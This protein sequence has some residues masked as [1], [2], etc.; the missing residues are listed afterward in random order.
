[1]KNIC[2]LHFPRIADFH[3]YSID[4]LDPRPYFKN[5]QSPW[6]KVILGRHLLQA[7]YID[8]M[9]REKDP[10]YM[11]FLDDFIAKFENAHVIIA[12]SNNPVHPEV[13]YRD[14]KGPVKIAGFTDDPQATYIRGIPYQWA[15]DGAF[16]ISPSYNDEFLFKDALAR[17]GCDYS[18]W[19]PLVWPRMSGGTESGLW[20]LQEAREAAD[21]KGDGFFSQRDIDLIYVGNYYDP[22]VDR[23]VELNKRFGSRL[24][25][26][27][28]WR[29]SGYRG[30]M[31]WALGKAPLWRRVSPLSD[32]E[33]AQLYFRARIGINM[34]LSGTPME[35]GNMR[36]YEVAAHGAM[37]LCDKGG[38]NAHEFIFEPDKEA[39]FYD[40]VADMMEKIEYYLQHEEEREKIARAGFERVH[41]DYDGE[42]NFRKFLDWACSVPHKRS[43]SRAS[44]GYDPAF[45]NVQV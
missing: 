9:Y 10:A 16:Y 15:F 19:W 7:K 3:G 45:K 35:T 44:A 30:A 14:L 21:K 33:R 31:R 8:Q 36:M 4:N 40:S 1:M 32:A 26:H 28:R 27:G 25:I 39:V 23:L 34:H 38:R 24:H 2:I 18:Y 17:W 43:L 42:T 5:R 13:L 22:K 6:G 37:L 41:R 29:L 12:A 11:R 20:P